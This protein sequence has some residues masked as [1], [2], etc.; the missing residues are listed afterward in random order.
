MSDSLLNEGR[1]RAKAIIEEVQAR[2]NRTNPTHGYWALSA[3]ERSSLRKWMIELYTEAIAAD[4]SFPDAYVKRG[5]ELYFDKQR[6]EAAADMRKAFTL[7]PENG[8]LYVPMSYP[9]EGD[10]RRHILHAGMERSSPQS[11]EYQQLRMLYIQTYWYEGNFVEYV[12]LLQEWIPQLDPEDFMFRHQLQ[13]LG[14]GFSALG[15]HELSEQAYRMAL[16]AGCDPSD[17]RSAAQMIVRTWMHRVQYDDALSVLAELTDI[18]PPD[19]LSVLEAVLT[20]LGSPDSAEAKSVTLAALPAAEL[21]GKQPGPLGGST[22]YYSF[23]LGIV[24]LGVERIEE[25]KE[26]LTRFANESAANPREWGITLRWEI[27]KARELAEGTD[28]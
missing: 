13:Q 17:K 8:E 9:F 19:E 10:E 21:L 22:S 7:Q 3:Q 12:R 18:I 5:T 14:S 28:D 2:I 16:A 27:A 20:V 23:L 11:L 6:E 4:E 15:Q 1:A 25:A 24:L 26:L